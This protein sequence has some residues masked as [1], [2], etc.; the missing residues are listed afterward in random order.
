MLDSIYHMTIKNTYK[1]IFWRESV[2][3]SPLIRNVIM[4]VIT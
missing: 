3:I 2:N 1:S 4:D